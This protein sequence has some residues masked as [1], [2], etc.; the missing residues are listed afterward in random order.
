MLPPF[1]LPAWKSVSGSR[2]WDRSDNRGHKIKM[3]ILARDYYEGVYYKLPR[4]TTRETQFASHPYVTEIQMGPFFC[5]HGIEK[6]GGRLAAFQTL[7]AVRILLQHWDLT[8]PMCLPVHP[9]GSLSEG[10]PASL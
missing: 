5:C 3:F 2:S 8:P 4:D 10:A 9:L 7:A 1:L 6:A